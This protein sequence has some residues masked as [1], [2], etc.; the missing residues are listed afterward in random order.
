MPLW[1]QPGAGSIAIQPNGETCQAASEDGPQA[2]WGT[3][4]LASAELCA[5]FSILVGQNRAD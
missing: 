2:R 1:G 5:H 3:P 4:G